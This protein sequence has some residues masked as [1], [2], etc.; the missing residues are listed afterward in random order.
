[1]FVFILFLTEI[2]VGSGCNALSNGPKFLNMFNF[3]INI[4]KYYFILFE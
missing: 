4:T 3:V 2:I 1:M